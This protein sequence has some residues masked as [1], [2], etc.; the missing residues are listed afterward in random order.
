MRNFLQRCSVLIIP[1]FL[2]SLVSFAQSTV[3]GKIVDAITKE[4]LTGATVVVKGTTK[5]GSVGL[6]GTFKIDAPKGSTLTITYIGYISKEVNVTG[7][8]LGTITLDPSSGTMKEVVVT[9][10]TNAIAIDRKTPIAVSSV[11]Q[12]FIEEKLGN[13]EFPEVLKSVPGVM[14]T[15]QGGGFGD[16]RLSIRGFK[17]ANVAVT[18]NG[19]PVNDMENGAVFW[20]NWTALSDVTT[21]MQAQRGLGAARI[22][23]PSL[24]GTVNI[25]T[26]S[27]DAQKGGSLA[28][29]I[30][31]DGYQKTAFSLSTGLTEK[32]WAFTVF[33]AKVQ[34]NGNADGLNFVGYNYFANVSKILTPNQTLSLTLVG[35]KQEHGNR[36][37]R[38]SIAD[39]RT[40]PQGIQFNPDWG[41]RNGQVVNLRNNFYTKPVL[42]LNH[43]WN[44]NSTSSLS[45]I[46]YASK[47][48]GGGGNGS[49]DLNNALVRKDDPKYSPIDFDAV[50]AENKANA[51]GS[52]K[53]F[54]RASRN[55]HEWYGALSTYKKKLNENIDV[56]AGADLR[57]Y[58]GRHFTEVTDLLGAQYAI[59]NR[60]GTG[61]GNINNPAGRAR[62]GDKILYNNDGNVWW[63]G[64]FLQGEYSKDNLTAFI[65]LAGSNTSYRRIDY[66]N[67]LD[68]DPAQKTKYNNYFGYQAK[69]GA[70]YNIDNNHNVFANIGYLTRAPFFNTAYLNNTNQPNTSAKT[71]KLFSYELGYG[72]R[73]ALFSA[74][75]NL[76]RTNYKDRSTVRQQQVG[77]SL[78]YANI[79]GINE[80]H[81]GVEFDFKLRPIKDVTL[82]GSLSVGDWYYTG[83]VGPVQ[84]FDENGAPITSGSAST[85][86]YYN[87][88]NIKVGDQAQTTAA[89]N[90]DVN[91]TSDL[92]IGGNWNHYSNYYSDFSYTNLGNTDPNKTNNNTWKIPAYNLFDLNAVFKFKLAG[93]NSE[94]IGNMNN[95]FNTNYISDALDSTN[96]GLA[97]TNV[98]YYGI[99]RTITTTLKIKF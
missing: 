54:L 69:G 45:T 28:Q 36:T 1:M 56:L 24:G 87:L 25:T 80:L 67:Y 32:G 59:D 20:S 44:I 70:N 61:N 96:S 94:I 82:S 22:A 85:L 57:Y 39:Y 73:S 93:L 19:M 26:R 2:L 12:Q 78:V 88:K 58:I 3:K 55:D 6:D 66:F 65:S 77:A 83:N 27:T 18:I 30:G 86:T 34:G 7:A 79:T 71:E 4:A 23:V 47:G 53:K 52:T 5:G 50:A 72:Y 10:N 91:V 63:Q 42:Q 99:G 75:V 74:N 92:K 21:S 81:Q 98:V 13:Q 14:V 29:S 40:A 95:V 46:V 51:D 89:L 33:G 31:T 48:T 37:T 11:N 9:G 76:Y 43:N 35:A 97:A 15:K 60:T 62:V 49:T 16:A 8:D 90:L 64:G 17:Q 38:S 41:Y 84:L 68:S